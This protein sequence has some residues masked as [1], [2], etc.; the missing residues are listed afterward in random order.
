M[1]IKRFT[2]PLLSYGGFYMLTLLLYVV[3]VKVTLF[4]NGKSLAT[5]EESVLF[6]MYKSATL[7]SVCFILY[8]F[9]DRKWRETFSRH[10]ISIV[11]WKFILKGL[12]LIAAI[13][14][15]FFLVLLVTGHSPNQ[16]ENQRSLI[17]MFAHGFVWQLLTVVF[18]APVAEELFYR[19][20]LMK[21]IGRFFQ[22]DK[23]L[24]K[25]ITLVI[26]SMVFAASHSSYFLSVDFILYFSLGLILGLS[27]WK[28]QRIEVPIIIHILNNALS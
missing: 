16:P 17:D 5:T 2:K 18:I 25:W 9:Y 27:Y 10:F 1:L 14:I 22:I 28:T 4:F 23:K 6:F 3:F 15:G 13:N 26:V 12:G 7:I 24:K 8:L 21:F 11:E 20:L 19:G